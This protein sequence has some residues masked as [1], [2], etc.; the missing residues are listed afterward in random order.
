MHSLTNVLIRT[1]ASSL[2]LALLMFSPDSLFNYSNGVSPFRNCWSPIL[3]S[4]PSPNLAITLLNNAGCL[5]WLSISNFCRSP[6]HKYPLL[7][8]TTPNRLLTVWFPSLAIRCLMPSIVC[9]TVA[10]YTRNLAIYRLLGLFI[11]TTANCHPQPLQS[12]PDDRRR[13]QKL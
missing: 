5:S 8:A 1:E 9:S 11:K 13:G 3:C 6:I 7:P 10:T 4:Q 2:W 12:S